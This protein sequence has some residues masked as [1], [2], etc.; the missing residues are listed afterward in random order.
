MEKKGRSTH[1][2]NKALV[3]DVEVRVVKWMERQSVTL[4][5]T[6]VSAEP[7][8]E[9]KSFDGNAKASIMIPCPA[10]AKSRKNSK[11]TEQRCEL[12]LN[13]V[14]ALKNTLELLDPLRMALEDVSDPL[15]SS[16]KEAV[17]SQALRELLDLLRE[18]LHEDARLVK[19]TAAMR[20]QRCYAIKSH[21]NGLLDVAR[22][23]YSEIIDDITTYVEEL[24]KELKMML[25]RGVNNASHEDPYIYFPQKEK[26]S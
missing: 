3:N 24:G 25:S 26:C 13:Y 7:L 22:K 18:V 2:E 16:V 15:L 12:R 9:G 5:S 21:V 20:T 19:G 14:I 10:A 6:S 23:I 11:D 4:L 8:H 1:Q 17:N